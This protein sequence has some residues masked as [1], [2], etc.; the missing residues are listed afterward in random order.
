MTLES[1]RKKEI[2]DGQLEKFV[3]FLVKLLD[4]EINYTLTEK[5]AE[6]YFSPKLAVLATDDETAKVLN[7]A[8]SRIAQSLGAPPVIFIE[9]K[10]NEE[11]ETFDT[12][13]N[14]VLSEMLASFWKARRA[15]CRAHITFIAEQAARTRPE[16][17]N[18][19]ETEKQFYIP[20]ITRR[21]WDQSEYAYI[22][23]AAYWDR[24][25]QLLDYIFFHIRQ[26]ED[27][28]FSSVIEKIQSNMIP[29]NPVI[30][31]SQA[32]MNLR[33]FQKT[34]KEDGLMW[35][36]RRRN[37]LIH[38]IG[39]SVLQENDE[40]THNNQLFISSHNHLSAL[41][42]EKLKQGDQKLELE[43]IHNHLNIISRLFPDVLELSETGAKLIPRPL[44]G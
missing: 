8:L 5:R 22:R 10:G 34:E 1:D 16:F 37:L 18:M 23:L 4:I 2:E 38:R 13:P 17:I 19:N 36:L 33:H 27:D 21:F 3:D 25:G 32:F 24:V 30:A 43:R 41:E 29:C 40:N 20:P 28:G 15:I 31:N 14:S 44:S 26:Y 11:R 7:A 9:E 6:D 35:L 42:K 39:F 12:F